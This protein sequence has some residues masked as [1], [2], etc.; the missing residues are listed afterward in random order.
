MPG[1]A[2]KPTVLVEIQRQFNYELSAAQG[3]LA[4]ALWCEDQNYQGFADYFYK[5]VEEER[6]HAK[7]LM[8]HL[9]ARGVL[10]ELQSIQ[11]PKGKYASL[12]EVAKQAQSMEQANTQGIHA[13]YEAA[14]AAKDYPAQVCLQWFINEQVE[15]EDWTDE[16]VERVSRA[17]C[18]GALT[19]LD[20]HLDK[21][22]GGGGES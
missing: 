15:E 5:Q 14:L 18:A 8:A 3:Y 9:M 13:A 4:M 11:A 10:P 7:K 20:R 17:T 2:V 12:L 21:V 16:M 6:E 1:I 19:D 22:L